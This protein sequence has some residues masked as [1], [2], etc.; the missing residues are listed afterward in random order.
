MGR[1]S[2]DSGRTLLPR[3]L[4]KSGKAILTRVNAVLRTA[5]ANAKSAGAPGGSV[6]RGLFVVT[7]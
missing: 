7:P 6:K 5:W 4:G 1:A 3:R 2:V